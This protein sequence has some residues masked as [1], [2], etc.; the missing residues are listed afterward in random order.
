VEVS[1]PVVEAVEPVVGVTPVS[2]SHRVQ[3]GDTLYRIGQRYRV[4]VA[5]LIAENDLKDPD[6]LMPGTVLKIPARR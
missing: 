6:Q 1:V 2:K 3:R 4:S 5:D